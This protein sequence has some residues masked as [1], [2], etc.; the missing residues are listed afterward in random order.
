MTLSTHVIIESD[1]QPNSVT[2][3]NSDTGENIP[4]VRSV[5]WSQTAGELPRCDIET[6]MPRVKL[7]A[8]ATI[9]ATCPYCGR[10]ETPEEAFIRTYGDKEEGA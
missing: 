5:S 3:K 8:D 2:V 1:G 6:L 10:G 9:T 7:E 4:L